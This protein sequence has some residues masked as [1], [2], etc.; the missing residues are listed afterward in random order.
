MDERKIGNVFE[1]AARNGWMVGADT[2]GMANAIV[3]DSGGKSYIKWSQEQVGSGTGTWPFLGRYLVY[4]SRVN[5]GLTMENNGVFTP[6]GELETIFENGTAVVLIDNRGTNDGWGTNGSKGSSDAQ[7]A[8][9]AASALGVPNDMYI[10]VDVETNVGSM[11]AYLTNYKATL[12][13][14]T[15][16]YKMGV[17]CD[18]DKFAD[19]NRQFNLSNTYTW[20]AKWNSSYS[21]PNW[22]TSYS[23]EVVGKGNVKM[24]QFI[25][26]QYTANTNVG[27]NKLDLNLTTD[28]YP[29]ICQYMYHPNF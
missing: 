17:Y 9:N 6:T 15:V 23:S 27:D 7:K 16:K 25:K 1:M 3:R 20:I 19:V 2:A 4:R 26:D 11:G 29:A 21:Y 14:G 12:E 5:E 13:S 28:S 24:W 22:P 18:V 10:F 8:K